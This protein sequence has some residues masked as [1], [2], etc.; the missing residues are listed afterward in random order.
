VMLIAATALSVLMLGYAISRVRFVRIAFAFILVIL[1]VLGAVAP[2]QVEKGITAT[3]NVA[4]SMLRNLVQL[5]MQ[6]TRETDPILDKYI[7]CWE[8]EDT[9][10]PSEHCK[11]IEHVTEKKSNYPQTYIEN[12]YSRRL[13]Q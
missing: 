1:L 7:R 2:S 10:I 6:N 8:S 9:F 3:S 11:Q 13:Q 12:E 5:T 4:R